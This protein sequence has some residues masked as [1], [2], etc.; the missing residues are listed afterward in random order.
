MIGIV[1]AESSGK[2]T[3]AAALAAA[4]PAELVSES[5]RT[6]VNEHGH[7]PTRSEQATVMR[8]HI[9]LED[10]ALSRAPT[11]GWVV[12]DGGTLMTAVYSLVYYQDPTLMDEAFTHLRRYEVTVWCDADIA[13]IADP[14]QR[15]GPEY[16]DRAQDVLRAIFLPDSQETA[17]TAPWLPGIP[18]LY[19]P[20][21]A[22]WLKASGPVEDRLAA[23]L[24]AVGR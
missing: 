10:A 12:S 7:A 21:D 22:R 13:W 4:L 3:L 18:D 20:A 9:A 19:I 15:D 23:V 8:R 1:G 11:T 14:G 24:A 2:S 16:R 17:A 5:L 6:F